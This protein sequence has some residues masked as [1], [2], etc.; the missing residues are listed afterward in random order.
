MPE[1]KLDTADA[2]AYVQ[3]ILLQSVAA[4]AKQAFGFEPE[5]AIDKSQSVGEPIYTISMTL[6]NNKWVYA[7]DLQMFESLAIRFAGAKAQRDGKLYLSFEMSLN[8]FLVQIAETKVQ[9]L[10]KK[11][12]GG[13]PPVQKSSKEKPLSG[14]I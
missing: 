9:M 8:R 10:P 12:A 6:P 4:K 3:L 14:F 5:I 1:V 11:S 13:S 7:V 2:T